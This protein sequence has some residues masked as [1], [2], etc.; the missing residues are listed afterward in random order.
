MLVMA[1]NDGSGPA[2]YHPGFVLTQETPY[3]FASAEELSC[4]PNRGLPDS[5]LFQLNHWIEKLTPSIADA[6]QLNRFDV[7]LR[8]ALFCQQERGMVPNLVA[9]NF[10]TRGE[11]LRAVDVLNGATRHAVDD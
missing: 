7:L 5:P 6:E 10:Y 1:E 8:R 3:S 9:V 4:R 11:L 2:W